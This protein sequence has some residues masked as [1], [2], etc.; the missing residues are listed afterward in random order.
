V[1]EATEYVR[2]GQPIEH[3]ELFATLGGF[4]NG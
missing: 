2:R 3:T 4:F 1:E